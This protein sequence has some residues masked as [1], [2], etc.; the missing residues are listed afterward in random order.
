MLRSDQ[1]SAILADSG[2]FLIGPYQSEIFLTI[3]NKKTFY[4]SFILP[5][6]QPAPFSKDPV[7]RELTGERR[8]GGLGPVA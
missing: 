7:F 6:I 8:S 1:C 4:S 2:H 5:L 3:S